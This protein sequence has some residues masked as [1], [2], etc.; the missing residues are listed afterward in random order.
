MLKKKNGTVLPVGGME[1]GHK[2]FGLALGIE[3]LTQGLSGFG[4]IDV[5][6]SMNLSTFIQ[7][8]DPEFFSGLQAFKKQ[9]SFTINKA[10]SNKPIEGKTIFIPGERA[11]KKRQ[12]SINE[13]IELNEVTINQLIALSKKFDIS[14]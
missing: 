14:F 12:I 11:L 1:Y 8:I 7:I 5:P 13:G 4:R 9:M 10:K 3:A 2:G 6:K